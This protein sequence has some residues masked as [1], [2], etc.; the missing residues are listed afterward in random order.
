[1]NACGSLRTGVALFHANDHTPPIFNSSAQRMPVV[2]KT[3]ASVAPRDCCGISMD[4][5]WNCLSLLL[6]S[7]RSTL[8]DI[9]DYEWA[10]QFSWCA[11]PTGRKKDLHYVIRN[12]TGTFPGSMHRELMQAV[13]GE[14]VD[15]RNGNTLDNRRFNLRKCTKSQ[16]K[17]NCHKSTRAYR[18][19]QFKGIC[20][21]KRW[22]GRWFARVGL[23]NNDKVYGE[24]RY[25]TPEEAAREYDRLAIKYFGEFASLNFPNER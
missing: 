11:P 15:H 9:E 8:I 13:K 21:D 2:R 16:N 22:P 17:R 7:G 12:R 3:F 4:E 23:N 24:R 19:K 20:E 10:S 6:A 1:M 25:N 14:I 5:Y 18:G